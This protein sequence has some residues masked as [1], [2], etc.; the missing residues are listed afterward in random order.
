MNEMAYSDEWNGFS[1]EWYGFSVNL[2]KIN[3][4][5][6]QLVPGHNLNSSLHW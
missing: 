4:L 6:D 2:K 3:V 1:D 5:I